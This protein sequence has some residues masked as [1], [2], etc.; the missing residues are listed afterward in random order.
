MSHRTILQNLKNLNLRRA[1]VSLAVVKEYKVNRVSQYSIKYVPID[2][3]LE[4]RLRNIVTSKIQNTNTVDEY[5]YDCPEPEADQ[6]RTIDS[7]QTD[8]YR[9]FEK[10]GELNPEE[11]VI[12][13]VEE[14]VNGTKAYLIIL[15]NREGIQVVGFKT[16]PE[17]WKMKKNKGL[18]P[19]LFRENRFEDLEDENVFSIAS[20]VDLFYYGETLFILSKKEFEH[21]L[22]FRDGMIAKADEMFQEVTQLNLFV[23]MEILTTRVGNNQRY[24]RK[25]AT[26]RNLGHYRNPQ[27]LQRLQ[28]VSAAKNWSIQFDNGQIV[29]TDETL[30]TILSLLQ[31]K[32][33]HSELTLEDFDV[34]GKID[35]V[36]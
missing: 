14:L 17:N 11:D 12:D 15:R 24:L 27:F 18:I 13:N 26:I 21:G 3:R 22:N 16:I 30:D 36:T 4:N 25:I 19:L 7:D 10:L 8:F 33:L 29:F 1:E 35:P 23:N 2:E 20:S 6:V 9:I 31:N 32:R 28:Q 5:S 34:D